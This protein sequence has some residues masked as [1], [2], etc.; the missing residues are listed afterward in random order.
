MG[1]VYRARDTRLG[2]DVALKI[3]PDEFAIDPDRLS[4][5]E[6]EAKTLAALNHP[7]VAAIYGFE[8]SE[9]HRALILE[10]VPGVD[11]SARLAE[12]PIPLG[13]AL[14]LARQIAEALEAAHE[15]GIVHR[16]LKPANV[17]L[18]DDGMVKVLDFGL[19]KAIESPNT[20]GGDVSDSPTMTHLA[21]EAGVI[22]G[23]APYMSPEQA[24]GK[25]LDKRA[26]IWAFGALLYELLTGRRA[27]QGAEVAD[28]LVAI[29]SQDVDWTALPADTPPSVRRLLGR[30]LE[31]DARRRLRDI[32][33]ARMILDDPESPA[34]TDSAVGERAV[35]IG[36]PAPGTSKGWQLLPWI[37]ASVLAIFATWGW[38]RTPATQRPIM[39]RSTIPLSGDPG[40][41]ALT[42]D[43][44]QLAYADLDRPYRIILRP[45]DQTEVLPLPGTEG[46]VLVV[47]SP[48]GQ[49]L[50]FVAVTDVAEL[51]VVGITGG[52]RCN[53]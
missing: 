3:L 38:V 53:F 40:S 33:E 6:R 36:R 52:N 49:Q 30:C 5:F 16:D 15:V 20:P 45:L 47:F 7:N 48:D 37:A 17:M 24:R 2:R 42:R 27:F 12:G 46:G 31:R 29:L 39:T 34:V 32:G 18:R 10:L 50:L 51:K 35:D 44:S 43:G 25:A 28:V 1:E 14:P 9:G 13:E 26:D 8:E 22:L 23:T 11:L 41:P 21:T 4:R 19:A